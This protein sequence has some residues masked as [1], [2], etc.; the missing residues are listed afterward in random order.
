M[1]GVVGGRAGQPICTWLPTTA[2]TAGPA[3]PNGTRT[4]SAC[5]LILKSSAPRSGVV[6][7]PGVAMLYLRGLF[8]ASATRS[9]MLFA[10]TDG[11]TVNT[12]GEAAAFVTGLK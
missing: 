1:C 10:G 9:C 5:V 6:P 2:A 11:C 4:T 3:P 12:F 8:F 7:T